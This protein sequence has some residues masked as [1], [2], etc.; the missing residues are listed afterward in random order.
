MQPRGLTPYG[1]LTHCSF[2]LPSTNRDSQKQ[3]QTQCRLLQPPTGPLERSVPLRLGFDGP[4]RL[5]RL[6]R[7]QRQSGCQLHSQASNLSPRRAEVGSW[8]LGGVHMRGSLE[9]RQ[10]RP[11]DADDLGRVNASR[12]DHHRRSHN[13]T[14]PNKKNK[15]ARLAGDENPRL[16]SL[17]G[18]DFLLERRPLRLVYVW[19]RG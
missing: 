8:T 10:S 15:E 18:L 7:A 13:N 16:V 6:L 19:K 12:Q 3:R 2:V 14:G 17:R 5:C 11:L 9:P 1:G 4:M